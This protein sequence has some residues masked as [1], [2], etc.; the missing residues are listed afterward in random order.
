M[1]RE[2]E[3]IT[4]RLSYSNNTMMPE[5]IDTKKMIFESIN[6]SHIGL[7]V[8][9]LFENTKS[10]FGVSYSIVTVKDEK[11]TGLNIPTWLGEEIKADFE[12]SGQTVSEFFNT[13]IA[14]VVEIPT[15]KGNPTKGV[16]FGYAE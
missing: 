15:D 2:R 13:V 14:N 1:A 8:L 12:K 16:T 7:P 3:E 9:G 10:R 11:S 4:M 5:G 6:S